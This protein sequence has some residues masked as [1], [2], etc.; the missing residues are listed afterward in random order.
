MITSRDNLGLAL[1]LI[2]TAM[3]AGTLPMSRYA[4]VW[5]DPWFLTAARAA[6][7]GI[8]GAVTLALTRRALPPRDNWRDLALIALCLVLGFPLLSAVAMVSVP[9]AHGGVVLGIL[10]LA[11]TAAAALLARERPSLGFW[12]ASAVGTVLVATFALR[13]GGGARFAAGDLLLLGAIAAGALGYTLS[14]RLAWTMPGWEV[15][16]WAVVLSLPVALPATL[17]LWPRDAAQAPASAW[18]ALAYVGLMSQFFGFFL[19]NAGLALAGIARVG[20]LQLL[21]PFFIVALAVPINGE[22]IDLE[23][24]LFA[25]AVVVTVLIARR[26]PVRR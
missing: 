10:P 2:G 6:M 3:F 16:A 19:W 7:A 24:L 15:I 8:A 22:R 12:I 13:D 25:L 5:L 4:V 14:G 17:A 18:A 1:G 23:T 26:Q 9:A 11:T 21:Q 20:Q